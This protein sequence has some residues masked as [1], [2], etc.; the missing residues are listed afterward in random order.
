ML[1]GNCYNIGMFL[2]VLFLNNLKIKMHSKNR[3]KR[4]SAFEYINFSSHVH[5]LHT[6]TGIRAHDSNGNTIDP[7]IK[8][9]TST[10]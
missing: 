1:A 2:L 7:S 8:L 4:Q 6:K 10:A 3:K 5:P 9:T